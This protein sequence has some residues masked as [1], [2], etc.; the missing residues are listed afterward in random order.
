MGT[1]DTMWFF[2]SL[3]TMTF[4]VYQ[5]LMVFDYTKIL[6]RNKI[7]ELKFLMLI[8]SIGIAYLFTEAFMEVISRI[9]NFFV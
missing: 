8:I 9:T 2:I 1:Y 5:L 3:F 7:R 6:R 4:I